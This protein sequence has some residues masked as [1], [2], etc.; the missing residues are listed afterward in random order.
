MACADAKMSKLVRVTILGV[1]SR[2]ELLSSIILLVLAFSS[3]VAWAAVGGRISGVITDPT[4]AVIPEA[5]IT[6]TNTAT[7]IVQHEQSDSRGLYSFQDLPIGRYDL[8]VHK[9]GF[10]DYIESGITLDVNAS[11]SA[12]VALELGQA[13]QTVTVNAGSVQIDTTSTQ[14]GEVIGSQK[15][16]TVPLNG[17]S[18][19]DLLALQPGVNPTYSGEN[20]SLAPSTGGALSVNGGR[21][22]SNGFMVNGGLVEEGNQNSAG[23][24]PNLDSIAEFRILT[25]SFDAEYGEFNGGQVNVITKSGTNIFHGDVFEFLRNT[26]LDARNF[27]SN[28]R[29]KYIQNQFGAT[30]GGPVF[31]K[32]LFFFVDY[33]GTRQDIGQNTGLIAVPSTADRSG[34][35]SDITSQLTGTV[36]GSYWASLLSQ[37]LGYTVTAG[38]P[39]Y[40]SGCTSNRACVLPN[41]VIPSAAISPISSNLLKYIPARNTGN[42][43]SSSSE[44]NVSSDNEGSGRLDWTVGSHAIAGYYYQDG[45]STIEPYAS[46]T[47]PGFSD[48]I[49]SGSKD[50]NLSDTTTFGSTKVNE[51]RI[52]YFRLTPQ[53]IPTGGV[54]V[55]LASLGFPSNSTGIVPQSPSFEGV[56]PIV[57]NDY[58]FGVDSYFAPHWVH[59]TYEVLDNFSI[60]KGSHSLKFGGMA[61]K[62]QITL[63][64]TASNNGGFTFSGIETG[65]DFADFLL[66]APSGFSQGIQAP[67]NARSNYFGLYAE[68][69]WAV[70]HNLI[71][72]YGLREDVPAPWSEANSQIETIVPGLQSK[73][74]P[75][76]PT[77][78]VFPGDP[79]IPKTLAPTR[80]MN[81]APRIGL[82]YSPSASSGI[83]SRLLGGAGSTSIRAAFGMFYTSFE[84]VDGENEAGDA[85]YGNF[86]ASPEPPLF[87]TPFVDRQTGFNNGQRFPVTIPKPPSVSQP[88]T[89]LNWSQFLPISGSPGFWYKNRVPYTEQYNLSIQRQLNPHSL[90]MAAYVGNQGHALLSNLEANPG[91]PALCLSVSQSSQVA[92][93]SA[94]CGPSGENGVFTT[95]AGT[96]INS[97]RAPLGPDFGSDNYEITIGNSNYNALELTWKYQNGP[98]ELLAGYTWSK[99]IDD[100]SGYNDTINPI[101]HR[102]SRGLSAFNVAQNFVISYYYELPFAKFF[103]PGRL[104]SGWTLSGITRFSSGQP[105]TMTETDDYSLLGTGGG[106]S[107]GTVDVPNYSPGKLD[108]GANPRACVNNPACKPYFNTS[109]FS[110]E[111]LGQLGN[112]IPRFFSGPGLNDFDTALLKDTHLPGDK[113]TLEMR[114]EAFNVFN[115]TQFL[116]LSGNI[117]N[118][119]FGTVTSAND[120]RI[121]QVAVK[122][123]F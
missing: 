119:T 59:N 56:P 78:W 89:T 102:L 90:I 55:S 15:I 60:V 101:N 32:K 41:A 72:N 9:Q 35:L 67:M 26:D 16:T 92:S 53:T 28:D 43:F 50:L 38:E 42:F 69:S 107:G 17:R 100:S 3:V 117:N 61:S 91:N 31:R 2:G 120:P 23:I 20:S 110:H 12:N 40:S 70:K 99:S 11:I 81:L 34:D 103:G 14:L 86:W 85:P 64:L 46:A 47:L 54:G 25:N 45:I 88:N 84:N 27:Y 116:A 65:S 73:I 58:S 6:A 79:G 114:F 39:Y 112:S 123:I 8:Q 115:H 10:R 4:G 98:S 13:A 63:H 104:T 29:G 77:G 87:A 52:Q 1:R 22:A 62:A 66:G 51:F 94:T 75:G 5:E 82:A 83:L 121:G 19:L 105:V 44:N 97:T 76:A 33:Q 80:Y 68:D 122:V 30:L 118:S 109:L 18:Y 7:G 108:V 21:E 95:A 96:V 106:G 36:T 57:L 24:V 48:I 74:F 71:L 49:A 113:I 93:G 111:V 37:K